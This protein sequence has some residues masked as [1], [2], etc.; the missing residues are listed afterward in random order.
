LDAIAGTSDFVTDFEIAMFRGIMKGAGA[1]PAVLDQ[2]Q[3]HRN[4]ISFS[5]M[6]GI[7]LPSR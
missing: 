5:N 4:D 7:C 3:A 1:S 6:P 2:I